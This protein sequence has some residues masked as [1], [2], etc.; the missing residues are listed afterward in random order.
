MN[1]GYHSILYA[2]YCQ[3]TQIS[4]FEGVLISRANTYDWMPAARSSRSLAEP[5]R[6]KIY[7]LH[8]Y[9]FDTSFLVGSTSFQLSSVLNSHHLLTVSFPKKKQ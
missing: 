9:K 4:I 8:Q 6:D 3:Q 1:H 5:N 7:Q 2:S